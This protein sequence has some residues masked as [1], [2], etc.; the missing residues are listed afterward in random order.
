MCAEL[1]NFLP[2]PMSLGTVTD[3]RSLP[4]KPRL[5]LEPGTPLRRSYVLTQHVRYT[6][7]KR[8]VTRKRSRSAI[9]RIMQHEKMCLWGF[10]PGLR[11]PGLFMT[12]DRSKF[13]TL[14]WVL[15]SWVAGPFV[16]RELGRT[17]KL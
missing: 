4:T 3:L 16:F 11:Q 17:G 6:Q 8:D 9:Q 10:R 5:M 2:Y 12:K 14:S 15:G 7:S 1:I 13:G